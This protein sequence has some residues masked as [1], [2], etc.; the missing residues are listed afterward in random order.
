M[1]QWVGTPI[2]TDH[3]HGPRVFYSTRKGCTLP[4]PVTFSAGRPHPGGRAGAAPVVGIAAGSAGT[5][6]PQGAA[7]AVPVWPALCKDRRVWDRG[8]TAWQSPSS[9]GS[10]SYLDTYIC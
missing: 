8:S 9:V 4:S 1:S 3:H 5:L 10:G 7:G 2:Q 6:A